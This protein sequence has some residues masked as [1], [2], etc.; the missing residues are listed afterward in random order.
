MVAQAVDREDPNL[1]A[2][3]YWFETMARRV[4]SLTVIAQRVGPGG[5][6][7]GVRVLSL[8]KERGALRAARIAK[9]LILFAR[10]FVKSDAVLFHQIPE[11][12][13]AVSPLLL[14]RGRRVSGLWYAHGSVSR[15]L[16]AAER[17][18]DYVFT[19]SEAGFRIPS[20]KAIHLGQ[21]VNTDLF[22]P[23]SGVSSSGSGLR[24]ITVGRI[25]PVKNLETI[26]DACAM[27]R[28]AR[29]DAFTLSIVGGPIT[30]HDAAYCS[31][32][33]SLIRA[34]GLDDAVRFYGNLPYSR[35]P[36]MLRAHDVFVNASATGSLDKAV[37]EAMACGLTVLTSNEAYRAILPPRYFLEHKS[38]ELL[39]ARIT[40][41]RDEPR[42]NKGLRD[43]VVRDHA[44]RRTIDRMARY[45]ETPVR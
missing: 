10:L 11:F 8:G 25:S 13:V 23:A 36:A 35:V 6:P 21:A 34:R 45:L 5:A 33:R 9:F 40:A 38:A 20:K 4:S 32:V 22:C 39:A 37:L 14:L 16:R 2:F 44:L 18:M 42:P 1:G 3:Y 15:R 41:F 27:L 19:S 24:L 28:N 12:A 29:Q 26:V 7:P 31:R 30:A 17:L 43:I